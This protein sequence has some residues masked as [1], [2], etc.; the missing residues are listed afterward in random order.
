MYHSK[1]K[2]DSLASLVRSKAEDIDSHISQKRKLEDSLSTLKHKVETLNRDG[3]SD[4]REQLESYKLLL[5]CSACNNR[6]KSHCLL[7]CMHVFWYVDCV[8]VLI[9]KKRF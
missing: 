7:K 5:K 3:D 2:T 1:Q 4:M 8:N 9:V 6:F